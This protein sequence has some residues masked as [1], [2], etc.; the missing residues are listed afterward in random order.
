MAQKYRK[1][2][3]EA[4]EYAKSYGFEL[5]PPKKGGG[6]HVRMRHTVNGALIAFPATPGGAWRDNHAADVRRFA[7]NGRTRRGQEPER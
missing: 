6:R 5:L 3:R 1:D 7:A 2:V 4:I